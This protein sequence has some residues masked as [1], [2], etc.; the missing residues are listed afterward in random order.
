[1]A[2]SFVSFFNKFFRLPLC[3]LVTVMLLGVF[4]TAD[5]AVIISDFAVD[6]SGWVAGDNVSSVERVDFTWRQDGVEYSRSCLRAV[7]NNMPA[8]SLRCVTTRFNVPLNLKE[9]REITFDIY[10]PAIE[11]DP[12]ALF[13][14]RLTLIGKDGDSTEH[15]EMIESGKWNTINAK[16]AAWSGRDAVISAEITLVVDTVAT[17][18]GID[19]FYIDDIVTSKTIDRDMADR[20][21]FDEFAVDGGVGAVA[22]DKSKI[23]LTNEDGTGMSL[24]AEVMI[25]ELIND[26]NR[27]RIRLANYTE[28]TSFTLYYSTTDSQAATED[29]SVE[30]KIAP[31]SELCDYYV[32]VG[33][34][35]QLRRLKFVFGEAAGTVELVSVNV[36]PCYSVYDYNSCGKI[37]S[38]RLSPDGLSITFAGEIGRDIASE[39]QSGYIGIYEFSGIIPSKKDLSEKTALVKG[40]MA[41]RFEL[42]WQI[43]K[44]SLYMASSAFMA[45]V[46]GED[47][48]Y[49]FI[50]S[51]FYVENPGALALTECGMEADVKG[52]SSRDISAVGDSGAGITLI[53]VDVD[54]VFSKN[55]QIQMYAYR[56]GTYYLNDE[57]LGNL[58]SEI[59]MISKSGCQVLLRLCQPDFSGGE[60]SAVDSAGDD[61]VGALSSYIAKKWVSSKKVIGVVCGDGENLMNDGESFGENIKKTA[62]NLRSVYINLVSANSAARVYI[63]LT[64]RYSAEVQNDYTEIGLKEYIPALISETS[65]HTQFPWGIAI[66]C[67]RHSAEELAGSAFV[68]VAQ[69]DELRALIA[70]LGLSDMNMIFVDRSYLDP[71]ANM[72]TLISDYVVGTY[73]ARFAD[74]IDAYIA[75]IGENSHMIFEAAR[76]VYTSEASVVENIVKKTL[77]VDDISEIIPG[78]DAKEL[79]LQTL[80]QTELSTE[81]PDGIMG[82]FAYYRFDSIAGINGFYPSYYSSD[83]RIVNDND[84]V[85]SAQLD[86]AG[87][88]AQ[89]MGVENV[90]S[91]KEDLRLTPVLAITLKVESVSPDIVL[92]VPVKIVLKSDTEHFESLGLVPAG[93]WTTLYVDTDGFEG[94][95]D[96]SKIE[97]L[98]GN[99][100]VSSAVLKL[101]GIEGLSHEYNDESLVQVIE[102]ARLDRDSIDTEIDWGVYFPIGIAA[103]VVVCTVVALILL[104]RKK[105]S[106]D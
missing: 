90:L 63:S 100:Q 87:I 68:S 58:A 92:S 72:S 84:N 103:V 69:C 3:L 45:V 70:E 101:H 31:N 8:D 28:S 55:K 94:A 95:K 75:V 57:Y 21:L 54:A 47:G 22:P 64:D 97:I 99:S 6:T 59:D 98:V 30:I 49:R 37:T 50:S 51:P 105:N 26:S 32:D 82:R 85:A 5:G 25:P 4:I 16:I 71:N 1:M 48:E 102:K 34:V 65:V 44:N 106:K 10:A 80:T 27:L 46:V 62:K 53:D 20:F 13:L 78:Y 81:M 2:K 29:K 61:F 104:S 15:L 96:T 33:D 11:N 93:E 36:V 66:E 39:N 35:S 38:C 89:W 43:P 74:D 88:T 77:G 79:E 67:E 52:L 56:G 60:N 18:S 41:T 24:D 91:V 73:S 17:A 40:T 42:S 86:S 7:C 83:F 9:Y 76:Y 12:E 23:I 19:S 14:V